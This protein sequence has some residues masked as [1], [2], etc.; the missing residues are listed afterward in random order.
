MESGIHW[1]V[2][3]SAFPAN[4]RINV[5]GTTTFAFVV[6][7]AGR[8]PEFWGRYIGGPFA[9]TPEEIKFIKRE[10]QGTCRVLVIYNGIT[11]ARLAEGIDGGKTDAR[12][13]I[14]A[15]KALGVPAG[16]CIF[17]DIEPGMACTEG[18]FRGWWEGM[19]PSM[20]CGQ[21]GLYVNATHFFAKNFGDP[22]HQAMRATSDL[23]FREALQPNSAPSLPPDPPGRQRFLYSQTPQ[24]GPV[25]PDRIHFG[26]QPDEPSFCRGMTVLWQYATDCLKPPGSPVGAVDF[27][28][29][30]ERGFNVMWRP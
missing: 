27:D 26:F 6:Q 14:A 21:G 20:Y 3:S 22:Y 5:K 25:L 7:Q 11:K 15:A 30:D 10:S 18:W 9:A 12:L 2:D 17:G 1:G 23:I 13:A 4:H 19:L 16:V 24:K 8:I 28:L 29:A